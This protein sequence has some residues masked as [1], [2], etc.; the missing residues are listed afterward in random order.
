MESTE[1]KI[2][3]PL[4]LGITIHSV[5]VKKRAIWRRIR[6]PEMFAEHNLQIHCRDR[7]TFKI[8]GKFGA[9]VSIF[10][11]LTRYYV[12]GDRLNIISFSAHNDLLKW[13][14]L[15]FLHFT[16]EGA[17]VQKA[18]V[19]CSG[20]MIPGLGILPGEENGYPLSILGW[21]IP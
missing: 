10:H 12:P 5:P 21:R 7:N 1:I 6:F 8:E 14:Q 4:S 18:V 3:S 19:I 15:L 17:E 2:F 16:Y 11:S 13:Q 9:L 20:L